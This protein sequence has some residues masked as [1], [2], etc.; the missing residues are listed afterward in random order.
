MARKPSLRFERSHWRVGTDL[1]AGVDEVGRGP[2][3]GPVAAGAV[4]LPSNSRASGRF[5]WLS[6]VNDSKV[7]TRLAREQL[8]VEIW[9]HSL[10]AAV[11]FVSVDDIDRIGIAEASR[12]AM[13]A[14]IGDLDCRPQHLLIDGFGIKACRLPQTGIIDGDALS[15]SIGCASIIA[16]VARDRIMREHDDRFPAYGFASN[17]GYATAEHMRAIR[18][19]GPCELHRKTFSPVREMVLQPL[20]I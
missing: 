13:L 11:A 3:A 15:I 9:E 5:H 7:L 17:K 18:T 4:V 19:V 20:L 2:L 1:V 10:S 14:A 12:Q 16:K 6:R 8:A